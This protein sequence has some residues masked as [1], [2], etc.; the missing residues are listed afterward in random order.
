MGVLSILP[1]TFSAV[2]TWLTR[3]FL[4]LGIITIGP[5]AVLLLYDLLLYIVR[6]I[7]HEIPLVGGRARGKARPRAPS[8]TERPSGHRRKFSLARTNA[9]ASHATAGVKSEAADRRWRH[10]KEETDED[11]SSI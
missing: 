10:L 4:L 9:A 3:L 5:W 11:S 6:S 1:E 8:L 2:E 7:T